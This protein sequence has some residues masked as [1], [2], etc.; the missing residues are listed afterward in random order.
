MTGFAVFQ[1]LGCCFLL[2]HFFVRD[3]SSFE[4]DGSGACFA[5]MA[6]FLD[7]PLWMAAGIPLVLQGAARVRGL[8][9]EGWSVCSFLGFGRDVHDAHSNRW[10]G[11]SLGASG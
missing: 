3:W 4:V 1:M 9:I 5:C 11:A 10:R 8:K 6:L 2:R 7:E